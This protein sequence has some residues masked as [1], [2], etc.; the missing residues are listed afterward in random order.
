MF[1]ADDDAALYLFGLS[2]SF[3]PTVPYQTTSLSAVSTVS[4]TSASVSIDARLRSHT[5]HEG[6][7]LF[8]V[9]ERFLPSASNPSIGGRVTTTSEGGGVGDV[10]MSYEGG[11]FVI[12]QDDGPDQR[13]QINVTYQIDEPE[14]PDVGA[15][16]VTLAQLKAAL[17][18]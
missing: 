7:V 18:R 12:M 15:R 9:P 16:A 11:R 5:F 13:I 14:I 1:A 2:L 8:E 4:G 10:A 3:T 17:A 6:D